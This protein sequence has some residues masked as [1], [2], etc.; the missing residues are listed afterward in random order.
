[1]VRVRLPPGALGRGGGEGGLW[2]DAAEGAIPLASLRGRL[3]RREA[4][5]PTVANRELLLLPEVTPVQPPQ[6]PLLS[7]LP[8]AAENEAIL[9]TWT[10]PLG[11]AAL[12]KRW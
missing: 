9:M 3:R 5:A 11:G 6:M 10:L 4:A 12:S 8:A 1:M 7:I 2:L